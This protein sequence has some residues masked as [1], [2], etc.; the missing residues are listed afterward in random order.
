MLLSSNEHELMFLAGMI[1]Y[2]S[3]AYFD[4]EFVGETGCKSDAVMT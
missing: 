1:K 2:V 3:S 4:I